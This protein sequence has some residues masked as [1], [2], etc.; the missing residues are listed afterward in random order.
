MLVV[1]LPGPTSPK[2][3]LPITFKDSKSSRPS[4]VLFR[5][6]NSV[7]FCACADLL[8]LFCSSGRRKH[9]SAVAIRAV[10]AIPCKDARPP[11]VQNS[12]LLPNHY[13]DFPILITSSSFKPSSSI[14]CSSFFCL[15]EKQTSAERSWI[16]EHFLLIN[17]HTQLWSLPAVKGVTNVHDP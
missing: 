8:I 9:S 10:T 3:P 17:A 11:F 13:N 5:R 16:L 14:I 6:R 1:I 4:L 15:K 7:S 2:A 12:L